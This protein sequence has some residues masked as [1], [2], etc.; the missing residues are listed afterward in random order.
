MVKQ[1]MSMWQKFNQI[2]NKYIG[3]RVDYNNDNSYQCVDFVKQYV[4]EQYGIGLGLFGPS[5]LSG[6]NTGSPFNSSFKRVN[7][8]PGLYPECGDIVFLDKT[9]N[10]PY[11]HV[12][13]ADNGCD[14]TKLV[15]IEQNAGNGNGS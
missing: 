2:I 1:Q 15:V 12:A 8:I 7:Y 3:K 13:V 5:A 11:G 6:W 9:S 4:K 10:N 14:G